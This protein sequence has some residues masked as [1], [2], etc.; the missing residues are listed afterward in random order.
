MQISL[1][2][3]TRFKEVCDSSRSMVWQSFMPIKASF[4]L[5]VDDS[6]YI[7]S[8][9]TLYLYMYQGSVSS[10]FVIKSLCDWCGSQHVRTLDAIQAIVSTCK[11]KRK[12]YTS[13]LNLYKLQMNEWHWAAHSIML[14]RGHASINQHICVKQVYCQRFSIKRPKNA[15][16]MRPHGCRL[17]LNIYVNPTFFFLV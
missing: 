16:T 4:S 8:N 2:L 9:R 6:I 14:L 10:I 7:K 1:F 5:I 3:Y 13:I 15:H 11:I 12:M 17:W